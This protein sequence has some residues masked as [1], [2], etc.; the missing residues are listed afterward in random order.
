MT[1]LE[2]I[3]QS[4]KDEDHEE[5]DNS[6]S[7][8]NKLSSVIIDVKVKVLEIKAAKEFLFAIVASDSG[9]TEEEDLS[10][11]GISKNSVEL[12]KIMISN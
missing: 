1:Q 8:K 10:L 4:I 6:V 2:D 12:F 3:K 11:V 5:Q 7:I 9:G